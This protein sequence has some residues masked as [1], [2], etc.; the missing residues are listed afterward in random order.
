LRLV[1][2]DGDFSIAIVEL[3]GDKN[4]GYFDEECKEKEGKKRPKRGYK[5][6]DLFIKL[7]FFPNL[8]ISHI[9]NIICLWQA[10]AV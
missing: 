2:I 6:G 10:F 5:T 8:L 9:S 4:D 1:H 7:H 3:A